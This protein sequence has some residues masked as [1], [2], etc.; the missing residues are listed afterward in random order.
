[1]IKKAI[2]SIARSCGFDVRR[3]RSAPDWSTIPD[4]DL[5]A[6]LYSPWLGRGDFRRYFSIAEKKTLI[7]PDRGYVLYTLLRQWLSVPGDVWECGVYKGG[8]AAMLAAMIAEFAPKKR[9]LLFD[10]FEGMPTTDPS[11]DLHQAGDFA[12]T[13]LEAVIDYVGHK[14][15][16]IARKGFI[17]DTFAGLEDS[18]ICFAHID[19]DIYR[20]IVDSLEFIWP[21]LSPGGV[22]VF[23]DY[24]FPSCPG[25]RSA[26]DDFFA[27][28]SSVPLCLASGQALVFKQYR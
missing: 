26:V 19:V 5:Y 21:R 27:K 13:S 10:T 23:D 20:S 6:P 1:M 3:I 14:G 4:S 16:C 15:I 25:A 11:K 8:T 12:D 22:V 17:P 24:G 28:T 9:L 2:Q 7:S 18:A